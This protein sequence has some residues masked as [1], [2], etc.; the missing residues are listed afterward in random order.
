MT[1]LDSYICVVF[2]SAAWVSWSPFAAT[3]LSTTSDR[4]AG[5]PHG[6]RWAQP[7]TGLPR[8]AVPLDPRAGAGGICRSQWCSQTHVVVSTPRERPAPAG[9]AGRKEF[10]LSQS[11]AQ[12]SISWAWP[13]G[14]CPVGQ[15]VTGASQVVLVVKNPPANAGE[16]RDMGLISWWGRCPGEE[17]GTHS[18]ILA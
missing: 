1:T 18:S 8:T 5:P 11:S 15:T 6:E 4:D 13:L 14:H 9:T 10:F 3:A 16:V 17:N 2:P 7:C 12:P